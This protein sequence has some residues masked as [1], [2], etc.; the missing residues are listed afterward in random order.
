M[1]NVVPLVEVAV[2]SLR[3]PEIR[4][5]SNADSAAC[6]AVASFSSVFGVTLSMVVKLTD[7]GVSRADLTVCGVVEDLPAWPLKNITYIHVCKT[8]SLY[9][10]I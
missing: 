2:E 4:E 5:L 6:G 1:L 10:C 8:F 9:I 7:S 3:R